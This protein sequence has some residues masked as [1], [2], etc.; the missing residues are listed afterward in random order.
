MRNNESYRW[1][2]Q[3]MWGLLL[4]AL[5]IGLF[6]DQ[7]GMLDIDRLWHYWPLLLVVVGINRMIGFPSARDFTSGLWMACI[8]AWLFV[9]IEGRWGLDFYN[10][11]PVFIIIS[12]ITMVLEPVIARR[13]Q[14]R[15]PDHE[16]R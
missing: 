5:G 16:K 12:G 11:W 9:V 3:M 14:S 1:R 2:R 6:L 8:G 13:L 7:M 15:E 4:V 10:S